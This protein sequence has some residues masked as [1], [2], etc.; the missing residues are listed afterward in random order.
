MLLMSLSSNIPVIISNRSPPPK[1]MLDLSHNSARNIIHITPT[2]SLSSESEKYTSCEIPAV[3]SANV[4][5]IST[6]IDEI[7]QITEVNVVDG[8]ACTG[9]TAGWRDA[10]KIQV[11]FRIL[12]EILA[13]SG[14]L[15]PDRG[16]RD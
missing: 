9:F 2:E 3:L 13:G 16:K 11:G 14:I 7:Q 4:G 8:R 10:S 6:K 15:F 1:K 5:A 12:R